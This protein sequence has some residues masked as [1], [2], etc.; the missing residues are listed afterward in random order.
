MNTPGTIRSSNPWGGLERWSKPSD[1]QLAQYRLT[2]NQAEYYEA[3]ADQANLRGLKPDQL[4]KYFQ[5]AMDSWGSPVDYKDIYETYNNAYQKAFDAADQ[6]LN[7]DLGYFDDAVNLWKKGSEYDES[8]Q[9]LANQ[10]Q[11]QGLAKAQAGAVNSG[12]SSGSMASSS[13]QRAVYD[14][15]KLMAE[16]T[17]TRVQNLSNA[18]QTAGKGKAE[19]ASAAAKI[20]SNYNPPSYSQFVNPAISSYMSALAGVRM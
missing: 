4:L 11:R 15:K 5:K 16:M 6:I 14:A 2:D 17:G 8:T 12:M 9:F 13:K 7:T 3:L 19:T 10:A 20:Y 18:Y 1:M